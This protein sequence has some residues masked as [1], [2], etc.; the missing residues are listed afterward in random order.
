MLELQLTKEGL[1]LYLQ[2]G[3]TSSTA[4]DPLLALGKIAKVTYL[5]ELMRK[6]RDLLCTLYQFHIQI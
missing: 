6:P 5:T 1:H 2:V 4:V 3:T